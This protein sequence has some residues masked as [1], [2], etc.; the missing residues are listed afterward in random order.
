MRKRKDRDDDSVADP[1]AENAAGIAN[2]IGALGHGDLVRRLDR[3][4]AGWKT[5]APPT[6][7]RNIIDLVFENIGLDIHGDLDHRDE[8]SY[9]LRHAM[10]VLELK[11]IEAVTLFSKLKEEGILE[12]GT[13]I[14]KVRRVLE[15][16]FYAKKIAL[17]VIQSKIAYHDTYSL[18]A[19]LDE[20]LGSY[21]IRY[22]WLED[23]KTTDLQKLIVYLLDICM[24]RNYRKHDGHVYRPIISMGHRTYAY[25]RVTDI[26]S[27]V[28]NECKKELNLD[29][30]LQLTKSSMTVLIDHMTNCSDIQFP[31]LNKDRG[32]FSF[33][34]GIYLCETDQFVP[35]DVASM[36]VPESTVSSNFFDIHFDPADADAAWRD[37]QTPNSEKIFYDQKLPID[38]REWVYVVIGR[39]LYTVGKHDGWQVI[40]MLLGVAG[41][42]KSTV[43][44]G[45]V[46]RIY[47]RVDV[48]VLSNNCEKQWA[49]SGLIN[50]LL[51]I[52]PEI[53]ADF[54][55]EQATFQSMVS[56]ER[57]SVAEKHK[58]PYSTTFTI[59]GFLSGNVLPDWKDHSGSISRRMLI[60]RFQQKITEHDMLLG[61]RIKTELPRFIVKANKAYRDM[62]R[63]HGTKNIWSVLPKELVQFSKDAMTE[64][65]PVA[66]FI[67]TDKC[68]L[69]D[70][71]ATILDEFVASFQSWGIEFGNRKAN[72]TAMQ[73][74]LSGR[75]LGKYGL[76]SEQ[77]TYI[78]NGQQRHGTLVIGVK[79]RETTHIESFV[80]DASV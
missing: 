62:A 49:V 10:S 42:G 75:E 35:Y 66:L 48:G 44:D 47:D 1:F 58:T 80:S 5:E 6:S 2:E 67:K 79:L 13:Q 57:I 77:A 54:S 36:H 43:V 64:N 53:K 45:L 34:N 37:I 7:Y 65:D 68:I 63:Q 25:E 56:A 39:V 16:I 23:V 27:F 20:R 15:S 38:V 33:R 71:F 19:N 3:L 52:C 40:P 60:F 59:P 21:A 29:A 9:G 31:F 55:L 22:R 12:D 26:K 74:I 30:F 70:A 51:W 11:E 78:V 46:G 24:E 72:T 61:S 32:V 69:G 4:A 73:A 18:D 8:G 14:G 17:S 41:S 76:S 28:H 50:K